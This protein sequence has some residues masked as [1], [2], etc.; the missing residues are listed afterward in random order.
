MERRSKKSRLLAF[1]LVLCMVA[2]L[3]LSTFFV[4]THISHDCT[5]EGCE[6][7]HQIEA[8]VTTIHRLS[9]TGVA[10]AAGIF[11]AI[12]LLFFLFVAVETEGR[13][14]ETLILLKVRMND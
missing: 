4:I 9:E 1:V 5:G 12:L 7:C 11:G 14:P 10:G 13:R 6:I 3:A 8:C 2:T